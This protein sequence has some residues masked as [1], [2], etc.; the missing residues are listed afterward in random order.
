MKIDKLLNYASAAVLATSAGSV[1]ATV[2]IITGSATG[3]A[4]SS[5]F[6]TLAEAEAY[7]SGSSILAYSTYN[8]SGTFDTETLQLDLAF[9]DVLDVTAPEARAEYHGFIHMDFTQAL[10]YT[11]TQTSCTPV[12][13]PNV[14]AAQP[15][16]SRTFENY[17]LIHRIN[18]SLQFQVDDSDGG[19]TT[20]LEFVLRVREGDVIDGQVPYYE[21]FLAIPA[22]SVPVPGAAWLFGSALLGMACFARR[23]NA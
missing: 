8:V 11:E 18:S 10:P 15:L 22:P 17:E 4:F 16:Q 5:Y 3:A 13:G 19:L 14:C 7:D 21:G 2:E 6:S 1:S 20:W 23:R 9:S 12:N